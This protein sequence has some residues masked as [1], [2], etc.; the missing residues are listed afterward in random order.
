[1][2]TKR[3]SQKSVSTRKSAR[4]K[5]MLVAYARVVNAIKS[6]NDEERRRVLAAAAITVNES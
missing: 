1:M 5:P 6:L 3:P 4:M 2:K